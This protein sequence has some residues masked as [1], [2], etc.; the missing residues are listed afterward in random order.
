MSE[1]LAFGGPM[2]QRDELKKT[3]SGSIELFTGPMFAGKTTALIKNIRKYTEEKYKT[4]IIKYSKDTRYGDEHEAISH[5]QEKWEALPTMLLMPVANVAMDYEIIG[6]DEGQFFPDLIEF[7]EMM[8]SYGKKVLVAALDGT[9]QR[10][11]FGDI[12]KLMPL[13]EQITKLKALCA[14]CGNKA[15][16]SM[17]TTADES[18]EVIGGA[19]MYCSVCRKCYFENNSQV[20]THKI[21]EYSKLSKQRRRKT[22]ERLGEW[23]INLRKSSFLDDINQQYN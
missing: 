1:L 15:S 23:K 21:I 11:P 9:F 10:K 2:I 13:C 16:F 12:H 20:R 4:L 5:D 22:Q 6:V 18:V 14:F 8:A 7:C 17:R 3:H 19:E